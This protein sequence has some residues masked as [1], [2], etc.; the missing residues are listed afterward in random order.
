MPE[1]LRALGVLSCRLPLGGSCGQHLVSKS[2]F[3]A[4]LKLLKAL[5]FLKFLKLLI[6]PQSC[7]FQETKTVRGPW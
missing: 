3:V 4:S 7:F 6:L 5:K 1:V 2:P